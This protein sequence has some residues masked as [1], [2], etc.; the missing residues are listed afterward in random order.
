MV[1]LNSRQGKAVSYG[2]LLGIPGGKV[3]RMQIMNEG[4]RAETEKSFIEA[5]RRL[6][7]LQGFQVLHVAD[8]LTDKGVPIPG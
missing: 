3:V 7:M 2:P 6:K 1:V 8:M 5:D 4:L